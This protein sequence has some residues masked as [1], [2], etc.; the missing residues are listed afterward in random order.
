MEEEYGEDSEDVI[1]SS[2]AL[3][4]TEIQSDHLSQKQA[5]TFPKLSSLEKSD[6]DLAG[7]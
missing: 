7:T 4:P 6:I 5:L 2:I 3:A 1:E